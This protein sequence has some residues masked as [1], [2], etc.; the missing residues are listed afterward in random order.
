[1]EF[2]SDLI[3]RFRKSPQQITGAGAA[4]QAGDILADRPYQLY[5][6][7]TK[8]MGEQPM[9]YEQWKAQQMQQ[10]QQQP[11]EIQPVRY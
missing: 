5:M 6:Q 11:Q 10:M 4:R 1:M 3:N 9:S 7:E 8:A 2:L